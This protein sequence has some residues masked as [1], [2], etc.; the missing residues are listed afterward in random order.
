MRRC[1]L[2]LE[3]RFA[4]QVCRFNVTESFGFARAD[5]EH[6]GRYEVVALEPDDVS[7]TNILPFAFGKLTIGIENLSFTRV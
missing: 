6:V 7:Y 5:Q 4:I 2:D 1:L 3:I